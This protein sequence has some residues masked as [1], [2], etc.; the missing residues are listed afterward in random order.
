MALVDYD[1]DDDERD[2]EQVITATGS[3]L[4][5]L[6]KKSLFAALPPPKNRKGEPK[7]IIVAQPLSQTHV[8]PHVSDI[9]AED[10]SSLSRKRTSGP[11][12]L[13][14]LLP[15][16]KRQT[17]LTTTRD[18]TDR[19]TTS[20]SSND[21]PT[22]D[23]STTG[24]GHSVMRKRD[25]EVVTTG[26]NTVFQP[27][28]LKSA[29]RRGTKTPAAVPVPVA[30][31]ATGT[32][33]A[34]RVKSSL[35]SITA[36]ND[37]MER[38]SAPSRVGDPNSPPPTTS[39][40]RDADYVPLLATESRPTFVSS[41]HP[42]GSPP[43]EHEIGDMNRVGHHPSDAYRFD[44]DDADKSTVAA[45]DADGHSDDERPTRPKEEDRRRRRRDVEESLRRGEGRG[46]SEVAGGGGGGGGLPFVMQEYDAARQYALN[47]AYIASGEG[48]ESSGGPV[49]FVGSGKHQLST[50]L[51]QAN[52]QKE[53]LE[54]SFA[55]QKRAMR[56]A[57]SKYGR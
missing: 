13:A 32:V 22:R 23:A 54:E 51:H 39:H 14:A 44:P 19:P 40:H 48:I 6:P 24:N 10:G 3:V 29:K 1:S 41:S 52:S 27:N 42:S 30:A 37:A 45:H 38:K 56:E 25:E 53:A 36:P 33:R 12:G 11:S 50:L 7:K 57:K 43:F 2:G 4:A 46:G 15:A 34:D 49:R 8:T 5:K 9:T 28:S 16:P 35:F 20:D 17:T 47:A 55:L 21:K 18:T 26:T 31:G